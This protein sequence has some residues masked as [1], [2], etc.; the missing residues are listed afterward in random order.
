MTITITI[1]DS[2][3]NVEKTID[4]EQFAE[5]SIT[6]GLQELIS[7]SKEI[8]ELHINLSRIDMSK[9]EH[10]TFL[11]TLKSG[12][13]KG[14]VDLVTSHVIREAEQRGT[15]FDVTSNIDL[16]EAVAPI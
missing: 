9:V 6:C 16:D 5:A 12:M 11:K 1:R 8:G 4:L 14:M 15:F 13:K 7:E 10:V 2:E 3:F